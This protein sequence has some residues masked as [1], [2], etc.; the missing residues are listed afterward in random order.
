MRPPFVVNVENPADPSQR[1]R[2]KEL[3][4]RDARKL[5][6]FFQVVRVAKVQELIREDR[7]ASRNL[8]SEEL[9]RYRKEANDIMFSLRDFPLGIDQI[10]P[11]AAGLALPD[12]W[13]LCQSSK[14]G[15]RYSLG[16]Y[17]FALLWSESKREILAVATLERTDEPNEAEI[18]AWLH[19]ELNRTLAYASWLE[20]MSWAKEAAGYLHFKAHTEARTNRQ[21]GNRSAILVANLLGFKETGIYADDDL[22][23]N[24]KTTVILVARNWSR[25]KRLSQTIA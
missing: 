19:P 8:S 21:R 17:H 2:W 7:K 12:I 24:G 25:P 11:V 6:R 14:N 15:H 5:Y 22:N 16:K 18:S 13:R 20:F 9:W 23:G 10:L 1:A 3:G 4:W